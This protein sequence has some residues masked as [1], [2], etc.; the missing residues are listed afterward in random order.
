[1]SDRFVSEFIQKAIAQGK[2]SISEIRELAQAEI[3]EIENQIKEIEKYRVR[4]NAL[5]SV[6]RSLGGETSKKARKN[7]V[8]IDTSVSEDKLDPFIREICV[9][10]CNF[11][12]SVEEPK[13]PRE[14]MD[15][16]SSL[17]ENRAAYSGIKWLQEQGIVER[18]ENGVIVHITTGPNWKNRPKK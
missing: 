8:T 7:Q 17:E 10:I 9:K 11:I 18:S 13:T 16:V 3:N 15:A 2:V 14:I 12:E 1:M 6:I 4:Q 5:K